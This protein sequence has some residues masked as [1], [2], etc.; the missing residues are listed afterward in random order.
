MAKTIYNEKEI[1]LLRECGKRLARVLHE[2]AKHAIAGAT[3]KDL[4]RLAQELIR[5][6][7]DIPAFLDYTPDGATYPYPAALCVSVND[8]VVHAIPDDTPLKDGDIVG[9][10]LGITHKGL[11]TDMAITVSVGKVDETAKKLIASVRE[12]LLKGIAVA[13]AGNRIGDI[14]DAI[15][16]VS[17]RYGFSVVAELGGHGVGHHVHEEPF[18]PNIGKSGTGPL[19][20][21]GMV[22]AL[23]PIFNEGKGVVYL[24]TSDGYT[25]KTRDGKR[26][27]HYEKTILITEGI[28]EILTK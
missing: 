16:S 8:N 11:I 14:A 20:E 13:R 3:P 27:A 28:A 21:A 19:L 22:L 1:I 2:V 12:A 10:D 23:E 15:A 25:Y 5:K 4:D 18:V 9:L 7:G 6:D 17:E 24:D 26:S